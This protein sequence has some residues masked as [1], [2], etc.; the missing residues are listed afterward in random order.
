MPLNQHPVQQG[1]V[2]SGLL[3]L[4]LGLGEAHMEEMATGVRS[5]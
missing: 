5:A 4:L 3:I 1:T 2:S